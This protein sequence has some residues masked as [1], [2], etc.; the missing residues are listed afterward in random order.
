MTTVCSM[1]DLCR[2]TPS[3]TRYFP[4]DNR[5]TY[6]EMFKAIAEM[7]VD[8]TARHFLVTFKITFI[9]E[10][11]AAFLSLTIAGCLFHFAQNIP[12]HFS[13]CSLKKDYDNDPYYEHI[14]AAILNFGHSPAPTPSYFVL[15]PK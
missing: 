5:T 6:C 15:A 10:S 2:A 12:R 11:L 14:V 1:C 13:Q 4:N 3:S 9:K 7:D 8:D